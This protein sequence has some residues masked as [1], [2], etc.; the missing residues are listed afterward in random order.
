MQAAKR[1]LTIL[2]TQ[3]QRHL[4]SIPL[5]AYNFLLDGLIWTIFGIDNQSFIVYT[6]FRRIQYTLLIYE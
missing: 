5:F 6:Y 2:H 1:L 3:Q 4:A